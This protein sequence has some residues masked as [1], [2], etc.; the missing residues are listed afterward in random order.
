VPVPAFCAEQ[1]TTAI[2]IVKAIT[3]KKIQRL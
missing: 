3:L 1:P 2:R